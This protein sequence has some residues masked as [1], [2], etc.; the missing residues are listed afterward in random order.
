MSSVNWQIV[1]QKLREIKRA[2]L[3]HVDLMTFL[4]SMEDAYE[5]ARAHHEPTPPEDMVMVK[6]RKLLDDSRNKRQ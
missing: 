2:E 1:A 4:N 6:M 5:Y 3:E